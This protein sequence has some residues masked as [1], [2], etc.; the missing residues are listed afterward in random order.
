MKPL[1]VGFEYTFVPSVPPFSLDTLDSG[2]V[3]QVQF[4]L[5][6]TG[7]EFGYLVSWARSGL[8]VTKIPYSLELITACAHVLQHVI[9]DYLSPEEIPTIPQ[10]FPS[11]PLDVQDKVI[12]LHTQLGAVVRRCEMLP[13]QGA[14]FTHFWC[15]C[16]A[17]CMTLFVYKS[18][19]IVSSADLFALQTTATACQFFSTRCGCLGNKHH[20]L[21]TTAPTTRPRHLC[22]QDSPLVRAAE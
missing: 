19:E 9:E 12:D 3:L 10:N 21:M 20:L 4:Q 17:C 1:R 16:I 15:C 11:L 14:D 8:S 5:H 7:A 13:L 18:G 22:A 6:A 2:Y